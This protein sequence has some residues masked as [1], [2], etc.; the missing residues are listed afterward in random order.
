MTPADGKG[1]ELDLEIELFNPE[2]TFTPLEIRGVLTDISPNSL[3]M[4]TRDL[5]AE[6]CDEMSGN[7]CIAR[8]TIPPPAT[9]KPLILKGVLFWVKH[10]R[11][12]ATDP[13]YADLGFTLR[14]VRQDDREAIE[15]LA[16]SLAPPPPAEPSA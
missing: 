8:I 2:E 12:K 10:L 3:R 4:R 5:S 14:N 9:A 13:G 7:Q 6:R 11:E 15:R 1:I 16:A